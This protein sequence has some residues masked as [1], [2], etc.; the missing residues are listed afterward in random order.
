MLELLNVKKNYGELEVLKGINLKVNRGDFVAI[1]G[2]SGSGKTTMLNLIGGIDTPDSGSILLNGED[3]TKFGENQLALYRRREVGFIFQSFN[4]LP[5]LTVYENIRIPLLLNKKD[6]SSIKTVAET[7]KIAD[8]LHKY[9]GQLSGGEQQRVAIARGI[10]HNP[11]ILL[12]DEPTGNLDSHNSEIIINLISE[13]NQ[14]FGTTVLLITHEKGIADSA[15][16]KIE[17]KDGE[18]L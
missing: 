3:I 4:L 14:K 10:V 8:K 1:V 11:S 13:I 6:Q 18:I 2:R 9:P 15:R 17:I 16:S 12:C 5:N 7:I